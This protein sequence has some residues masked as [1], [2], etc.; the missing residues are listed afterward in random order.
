MLK[1]FHSIAIVLLLL[2]IA[3]CGGS[4]SSSSSPTSPTTPAAANTI[5]VQVRDFE[6][7]P[8]SVTIQAGQTVRWVFDGQDQTH[9]S[10]AQDMTWDSQFVFQQVGDTFQWASTAADEGM[11]FAYS[12]RTHDNSH[13]MKGSILVG[14]NAPAP[15]AGY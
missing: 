14:A 15:P 10:T 12:C 2:G 8:K 3:G 1:R 11:T 9:T 13:N 5:T 7:V 6:F 4:G